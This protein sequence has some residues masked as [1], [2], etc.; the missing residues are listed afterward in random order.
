MIDKTTAKRLAELGTAIVNA[1]EELKSLLEEL[2]F[3][4]F[5]Q[6]ERE[7]RSY[8]EQS[9]LEKALTLKSQGFFQDLDELNAASEASTRIEKL[10]HRVNNISF[11]S[12]LLRV[13]AE[14]GKPEHQQHE[15]LVQALNRVITTSKSY[16]L[17]DDPW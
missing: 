2:R 9:V 11:M 10:Y 5:D 17:S 14:P 3:E 16:I 1:T 7:A 12:D 4:S 15:K 13:L 8:I 6:L